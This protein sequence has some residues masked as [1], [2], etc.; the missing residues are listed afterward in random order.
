MSTSYLGPLLESN[1]CVIVVSVKLCLGVI[2]IIEST[3]SV[4]QLLRSLS[5]ENFFLEYAFIHG[6]DSD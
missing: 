6:H 4:D 3:G 1:Y 5:E 2:D